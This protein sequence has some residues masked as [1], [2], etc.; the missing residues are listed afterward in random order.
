MSATRVSRAAMLETAA[1]WSGSSACCIPT[2]KPRPRIGTEIIG[3]PFVATALRCD[4][5]S[6]PISKVQA[7]LGLCCLAMTCERSRFHRA[8]RQPERGWSSRGRDWRTR[9]EDGATICTELIA[10]E[11]TYIPQ[12]ARGSECMRNKVAWRRPSRPLAAQTRSARIAQLP[13]LSSC[14]AETGQGAFG[15]RGGWPGIFARVAYCT[16][17]ARME[18]PRKVLRDI[19]FS[20]SKRAHAGSRTG[21][22]TA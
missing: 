1:I 19:G 7:A 11:K 17:V 2:R 14:R 22:L 3:R 12:S 16:S 4:R 5:A 21:R 8:T 13:A 9:I 20:F 10:A 15:R 6:A 18:G